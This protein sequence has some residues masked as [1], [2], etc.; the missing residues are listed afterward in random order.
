MIFPNYSA[1]FSL[2]TTFRQRASEFWDWFRV[3][4]LLNILLIWLGLL[5]TLII[6]DQLV[7]QDWTLFDEKPDIDDV[8]RD[9]LTVM[10]AW[11]NT[12]VHLLS[13]I[14]NPFSAY[15]S[16]TNDGLMMPI[17]RF[18]ALSFDGL[19]FRHTKSGPFFSYCCH[20]VC[21]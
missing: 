10:F 2:K 3:N 8:L 20:T 7:A 13:L 1:A 12:L 17:R 9:T 21:E 11:M 14:S 15:F 18:L 5:S 16:A 4:G 19:Y 6:V